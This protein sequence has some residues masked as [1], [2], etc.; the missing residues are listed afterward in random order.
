M[1]EQRKC[2]NCG[3]I[4]MGKFCHVCGQPETVKRITIKSFIL[5][6]TAKWI[7]WDNKFL[8]TVQWLTINPGQVPR[9]Y[10]NGNRVRFVGPLGYAFLTTAIMLIVYKLFGVDV[11]E[12]M[13]SGQ[14]VFGGGAA[15]TR[16]Q[17]LKM[18]EFNQGMLQVM[19]E[20]FRFMVVIMIPFLA[21][22]GIWFYRN[23]RNR[24]NY[25]E[26]C[27]LFFYLAG[28][29]IWVNI[30]STP[31]LSYFGTQYFW[32]LSIF[33]YGYTL[34]GIISFHRQFDFEG[35]VRGVFSYIVGFFLFMVGILIF[36]IVYLVFFTD[37]IESVKQGVESGGG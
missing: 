12:L 2:I 26:L 24:I 1:P 27:V 9:E 28:H 14:E 7:G 35:I 33:S 21:L 30:I 5:D 32:V 4:L 11:K 17:D 16:P 29:T 18:Q 15:G 25:L 23:K 22:A 34:W 31:F 19:A 20:N 6:F 36:M 8:R 37:F 3:A 10:I 13:S